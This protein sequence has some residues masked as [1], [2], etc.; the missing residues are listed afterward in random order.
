M[1]QLKHPKQMALVGPLG[2]T[3]SEDARL[4]FLCEAHVALLN[5]VNASRE[6]THEHGPCWQ[7]YFDSLDAITNA[8]PETLSGLLAKALAAKS[9][10][11]L[12]DGS[13]DPEGT[14]GEV[15]AWNFVDDL[16]R[17]LLKK[18]CPT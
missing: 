15:W 18:S 17:I 1:G 11:R 10:A 5:A 6:E 9:E 2:F 4:I 13:E 12:P 14:V 16:C 8:R 3:S 7:A